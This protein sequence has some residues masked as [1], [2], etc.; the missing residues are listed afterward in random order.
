[1][2]KNNDAELYPVLAE[3]TCNR[4]DGTSACKRK[5]ENGK[6]PMKNGECRSRQSE[7]YAQMRQEMA[8]S[9]AA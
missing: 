8:V 3:F 5:K 4:K 2:T 7:A 9:I 1:M 6:C